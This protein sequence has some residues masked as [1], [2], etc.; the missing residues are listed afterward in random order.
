M[1]QRLPVAAAGRDRGL[2]R[3]RPPALAHD[4]LGARD[5]VVRNQCLARDRRGPGDHRRARRARLRG[6]RSRGALLRALRPRDVHRR[7]GARRR[8]GRLDPLRQGSGDATRARSPTRRQPRSSSSAA[9]R[10]PHSRS[11]RGSGLPRRCV[12]GRPATGTA[13]S[14]SSTLSWPRIPTNANVLYNLACAESRSGRDGA[15]I[16]HLTRAVDLVPRFAEL[17]QTD[18]DLDAIRGDGRFPPPPAP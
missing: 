14:R 9:G 1:T 11:R 18:G 15:A 8:T 4:P 10:G 3:G 16:E 7:R 17:A 2:R 6:R 12:A 5:R 13:R